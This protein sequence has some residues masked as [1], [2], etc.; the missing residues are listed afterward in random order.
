MAKKKLAENF[1]KCLPLLF[2]HEGGYCNDAHDPGGATKWGITHRDLAAWLGRAVTTQ[3]VRNITQDLA[4]KIYK[5]KYWTTVHGDELPSGVDY[6]V[7]DYGVNSGN[8]R[9]VQTLQRIVGVVADGVVGGMTLAA[10][11]R[12][13]PV[14]LINKIAEARLSF[15]HRL[16]TWVYFGK[17]WNRRVVQVKANALAWATAA[18]TNKPPVLVPL[19]TDSIVVPTPVNDNVK[20]LTWWEWAFGKKDDKVDNPIVIKASS[21]WTKPVEFK[22]SS[23]KVA[24]TEGDDIKKVSKPKSTVLKKPTKGPKKKVAR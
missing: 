14:D 20:P 5:A 15:L 16:K 21:K 23:F 3:D 7:F 22:H 9:S 4:A 12:M 17:G 10:V 19:V 11:N 1:A 13:D 6:M 24:F 18:K 8:K 2:E